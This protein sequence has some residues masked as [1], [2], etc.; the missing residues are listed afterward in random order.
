MASRPGFCTVCGDKRTK[1]PSGIC[2]AC[3]RAENPPER[4]WRP[5]LVCGETTTSKKGTHPECRLAEPDPTTFIALPDGDWRF[6][7]FRRVQV[8]V[9]KPVPA[10][11]PLDPNA[12]QR[13]C[14]G[15]G[16]RFELTD[17]RQ[18]Y[19]DTLCRKRIADRKKRERR[20][21]SQGMAE[22]HHGACDKWFLPRPGRGGSPQIYCSTKCK[23]AE[24]WQRQKAQ[25]EA[26]A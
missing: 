9:P 17:P 14:I 4:R 11:K 10:P 3:E 2:Q 25:K 6:D 19:C 16:E 5:C 22:C 20:W 13:D 1:Q 18:R 12:P 8:W 21:A 24:N 15:C 7:P 26:A 23:E